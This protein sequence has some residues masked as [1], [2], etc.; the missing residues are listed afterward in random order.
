MAE[1]QMAAA[2]MEGE[3]KVLVVAKMVVA[4]M[5]VGGTWGV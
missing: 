4:M 1:E 2:M 5:A 3:G